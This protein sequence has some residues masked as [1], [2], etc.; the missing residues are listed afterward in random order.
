MLKYHLIID[1]MLPS[2]AVYYVTNA[3]LAGDE[4]GMK[5]LYIDI[6]NELIKPYH[7]ESSGPSVALYEDEC[8][9]NMDGSGP[10]LDDEEDDGIYWFYLEDG[11]RID[12]N[13][14]M[15]AYPT[16]V[17][18]ED[19]KVIFPNCCS[20]DLSCLKQ[21]QLDKLAIFPK[22][23][24]LVFHSN[25]Q[26]NL[27]GIEILNSLRN[28]VLSGKFGNSDIIDLS[29]LK[30]LELKK[31]ELYMNKKCLRNLN[32]ETLEELRIVMSTLENVK[33]VL[34]PNLKSLEILVSHH[35]L[36]A[37]FNLPQNCKILLK[38]RS[39]DEWKI[40]IDSLRRKYPDFDIKVEGYHTL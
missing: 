27:H 36:L 14:L 33:G 15:G 31:L 20:I 4:K 5:T 24:S 9:L 32:I 26:K 29:L 12:T 28:L 2:F 23:H 34:L 21:F 11:S 30:L 10:W 8:H 19:L 6:G 17:S 25:V 22:L 35:P 38:K 39:S 37:N 3:N 16:Y 13:T 1:I 40:F 18:L 7:F